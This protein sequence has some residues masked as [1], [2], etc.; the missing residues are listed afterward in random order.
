MYYIIN[1]KQWNLYSYILYLDKSSYTKYK[2][3]ATTV[4]PQCTKL[5][6]T[7]S[8]LPLTQRNP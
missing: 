3:D 7:K 8:S 6:K 2:Y 5:A 4:E 1:F